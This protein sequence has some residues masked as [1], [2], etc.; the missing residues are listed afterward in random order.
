[1]QIALTTITSSE[2]CTLQILQKQLAADQ[3]HAADQKQTA[4]QKRKRK[5]QKEKQKRQKSKS[6][7]IR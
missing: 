1:V 7:S 4:D 6:G 3:K 2:D 5:W